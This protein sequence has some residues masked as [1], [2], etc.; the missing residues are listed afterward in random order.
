MTFVFFLV[1]F[2]SLH[3]ISIPLFMTGE[4]RLGGQFPL[5]TFLSLKIYFFFPDEGDSPGR[6]QDFVGVGAVAFLEGLRMK[7]R[8]LLGL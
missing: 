7:K 2:F 3:C 6:S 5:S 4:G 1:S 8:K